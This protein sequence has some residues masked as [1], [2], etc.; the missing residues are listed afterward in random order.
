MSV[1]A[2]RMAKAHGKVVKD[3]LRSNNWLDTTRSVI[4]QRDYIELP[5]VESV[6]ESQL[7]NALPQELKDDIE[8]TTQQQP[9]F[10]DTQTTPYDEISQLC[11]TNLGLAAAELKQLPDKWELLG[12]VLVLRLSMGLKGHWVDIAKVYAEVLGA[13]AVLRRVDKIKGIYR[14]PGVELI[15]GKSTEIMHVENK[16]K[17]KFDAL[18]VMYSSGNIDERIRISTLAKPEDTVVDMFAGIGY[19][20]IP[21]AVHSRPKSVTS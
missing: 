19:F 21:I 3:I 8:L 20:A 12:D 13:K 2:L 5:V 15:T 14:E 18:K 7:L 17:F 10:K 11:S 16:I 6:S 1:R 9:V 4:R